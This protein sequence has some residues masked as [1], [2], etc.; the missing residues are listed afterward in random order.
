MLNLFAYG[1]LMDPDIMTQVSGS[2]H[3]GRPATLP[4]Y[5]RRTLKK[6]VYPA[7]IPHADAIVEGVLY[8]DV[9]PGAFD[10]LD[11]FEGPL[12]VRTGVLVNVNDE[13]RVAAQ[14]YVLGA[15]HTD[16]LSDTDWSYELFLKRNKNSFQSIYRG[17]HSLDNP[18][19]A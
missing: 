8:V 18:K 16:R 19:P 9:S 15:A 1:T 13:E 11:Q 3:R 12:Y 4:D 7:I 14:T 2:A 6:E 10:R 5:I 17:F